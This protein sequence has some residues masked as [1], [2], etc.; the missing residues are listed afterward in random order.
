MSQVQTPTAAR[1][2][3]ALLAAARASAPRPD[4]AR[5]AAKSFERSVLPAVWAEIRW[6]FTPPRTWLMGVVTNAVFAVGWLVVQPLTTGRHHD[7]AVLVGIYFSSWVLADVTT[8]NLLG[9]DHYRV[10]Q[11]LANGVPFWRILLIKNLALLT[12]VG[13]PTLATAMVLTLWLQTPGRLAVTIPTVA[14]PIVSWLGVGNLISVL[15]PVG[16]EPLL[17]R[18]RQRHDRQRTAGWLLALTLPYALYYVADPV[19]GVEHR[20]LWQQLPALIWPIFGRDTKSFV[21]LATATGVWV[22]G[23]VAAVWWVRRHGLQIK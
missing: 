18:W 15:H 4:A 21:H 22:A 10:R 23:T 20:V 5:R 17:R 7:W 9:L 16:V 14:V 19:A 12:I 8:T 3:A 1:M 6:A 11:A 13:V 2:R